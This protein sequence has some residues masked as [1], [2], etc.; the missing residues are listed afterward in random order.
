[1]GT[2][3]DRHHRRLPARLDHVEIDRAGHQ[4]GMGHAA[5]QSAG[6]DARTIGVHLL[7]ERVDAE[8][9]A[10]RQKCQTAA[11]I[12]DCQIVPERGIVSEGQID[13]PAA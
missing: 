1:M 5:G 11:L 4:I 9:E 12:E 10:M 13:L 7:M 8:A 3:L 2:R 6:G